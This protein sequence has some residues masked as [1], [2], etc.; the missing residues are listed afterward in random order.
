[1]NTDLQISAQDWLGLKLNDQSLSILD[2]RSEGEYGEGHCPGAMNVPILNNDHRQRV[3]VEYKISG[4]TKAME[5]GYELVAP[6][7]QNMIAQWSQALSKQT[8][9]VLYCWRGG[10]RSKISAEW[11]QVETGQD[12][13]RI[14]GGYK[15]LRQLFLQQLEYTQKSVTL[16]G[17][18]TGAGKTK[19]LSGLSPESVV[20]LEGL[21]HHRG[22]AFGARRDRP[23]QT[24]QNFEN[25]LALK[26]MTTRPQI[27]VEAESRLIGPCTIPNVL[28]QHMTQAPMVLLE[29]SIG[30]RTENILQTYIL[31]ENL[32]EDSLLE[33]HQHFRECLSHI[34]NRLGGLTYAQILQQLDDAFLHPF[35]ADKHRSWI[36][37]LL[38]Q[39]YDKLYL[40]SLERFQRRVLF[41]GSYQECYEFFKDRLSR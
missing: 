32:K 1:M 12:V 36:A 38:E 8:S 31:D 28:F 11:L 16:L 7:R 2:V 20:D 24:Q 25:Q 30:K 15:A 39:Y 35:D 5:L 23:P 10:L 29:E 34:H 17:G 41:R 33:L 27:I 19:L 3:G 4:P 37:S 9:K 22:S 14:N 18:C 13:Y 26:L 6:R 40:H 21:A